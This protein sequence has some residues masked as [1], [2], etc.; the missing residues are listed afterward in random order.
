MNKQRDFISKEDFG[1]PIAA[2]E[3][4]LLTSIVG[5]AGNRDVAIVDIPNTFI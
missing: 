4:V 3:L 2:T 5:A 1:S